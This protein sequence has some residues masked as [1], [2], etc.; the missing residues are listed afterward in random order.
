MAGEPPTT[1]T[2]VC[3]LWARRG[4]AGR[5]STSSSPTNHIDARSAA[6]PSRPMP[7]T[8]TSPARS[9]PSPTRRP[10][11]YA[12][13]VTVASAVMHDPSPVSPDSPEG[14][15]TASTRAGAGSGGVYGRLSPV[16]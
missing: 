13:K 8:S 12:A 14:M 2:A 16:P 7:T 15:S 5:V 10:G 9:G 11:L 3:H 1:R 4:R 6:G